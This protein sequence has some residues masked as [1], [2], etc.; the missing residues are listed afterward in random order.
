MFDMVGRTQRA[1]VDG[2]VG[3]SW[4]AAEILVMDR[5]V[6]GER[7]REY[8]VRGQGN[9]DSSCQARRRDGP[10]SGGHRLRAILCRQ[11]LTRSSSSVYTTISAAPQLVGLGY[12]P[13][14]RSTL[15]LTNCTYT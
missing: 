8:R 3:S 6:L 14:H 7:R 4:V 13:E 10:R 11:H 12:L 15:G 9:K 2:K 1:T 5:S